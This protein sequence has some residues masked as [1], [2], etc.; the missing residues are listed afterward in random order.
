MANDVILD[1]ITSDKESTLTTLNKALGEPEDYSDKREK[2]SNK[3]EEDN[4]DN[5]DKLILPDEDEEKEEKDEEDEEEK[6][7]LKDDDED[8]EK[9]E[10]AFNDVPRRQEIEKKYPGIFKEFKGLEKA[11]YREQ[12]YAETFASPKEAQF[13]KQS[14]EGYRALEGNLVNGNIK[15]MLGALKTNAPDGFNKIT[16]N[17]LETLSEIDKPAYDASVKRILKGTLHNAYVIGEEDGNDQLKIAA[18][19]LHKAMFGTIKISPLEG[20]QDKLDKDALPNDERVKLDKER[21]EFN[22]NQLRSHVNDVGERATNITRNIIS[23]NIDPKENMSEYVRTKAEDDAFRMVNEKLQS[24]RRFQLHLDRLWKEA[25]SQGFNS[26]SKDKIRNTLITQAKS[27]L[28]EVLSSVRRSALQGFKRVKKD[29]SS[30]DDTPISRGNASRN[31]QKTVDSGKLDKNNVPRG[32][33]IDIIN[34]IHG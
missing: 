16:N 18:Q 25:A 20:K 2:V 22:E 30:R 24:D 19:L 1:D 23:K 7:E 10:L 13:A 9:D 5:E 15:D 21:R 29:D 32:R 8:T 27:F 17:L 4:D 28:P 3:N 31:G 34:K 11:I 14:L 12:A 33:T 26:A 6:I